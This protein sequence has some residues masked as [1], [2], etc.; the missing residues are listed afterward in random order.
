MSNQIVI[1]SLSQIAQSNN[2][3][4]AESFM[5]ADCILLLDESGSMDTNDATDNKTRRQVAREEVIRLQKDYPGKIALIAFS[6]YPVFCPAGIPVTLD[7]STNLYS[8]LE[9]IKPC[10]NTGMK[11]IIVSD[12]VP[13]RPDE[14]IRLAGTF[15]TRIDVVFIG[16]E[17][18]YQGGRAF[19]EKLAKATGGQSLKSDTPGLLGAKVET[20]LLIDK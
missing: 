16:N 14:C 8:A 2:Q 12:G 4:L 11:I 15:K 5:Q 1:G 20:L 6:D 9:Y 13:S 3:S 18:D 17:T 19:L 10:D 7:G